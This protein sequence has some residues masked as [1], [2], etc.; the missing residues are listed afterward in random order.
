MSSVI[1][2]NQI[3]GSEL[4]KKVGFKHSEKVLVALRG[5]YNLPFNLD[6]PVLSSARSVLCSVVVADVMWMKGITTYN[7]I[8]HITAPSPGWRGSRLKGTHTHVCCVGKK[9]QRFSEESH[10]EKVHSLDFF[11]NQYCKDQ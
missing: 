10:S 1:P 7:I 5:V 4:W 8:S 11:Y 6:D 2:L 9:M 3:D